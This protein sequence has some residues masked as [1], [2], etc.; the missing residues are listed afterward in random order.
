LSWE[1]RAN[2][3]SLKNIARLNIAHYSRLLA[4][5]TDP[6]KRATIERLLGEEER[7]LRDL[8]GVSDHHNHG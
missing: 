4:N 5:E 2:L 3:D 1:S 8:E 7:R 6:T